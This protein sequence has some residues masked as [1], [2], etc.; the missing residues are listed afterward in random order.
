MDW[1]MQEAAKDL[2]N[3][4]EEATGEEHGGERR[5]DGVGEDGGPVIDGLVGAEA[6]GALVEETLPEGG[7][8]DKQDR[9]LET[10]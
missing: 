6:G 7:V 3:A 1:L 4:E 8:G 5:E 9:A 10:G 2:V